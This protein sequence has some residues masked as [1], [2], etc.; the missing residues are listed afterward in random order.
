[1]TEKDS[2]KI[3]LDKYD[4]SMLEI[5]IDFNIDRIDSRYAKLRDAEKQSLETL[6]ELKTKIQMMK[7]DYE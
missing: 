4:L 1:M 3:K 6:K 2:S 5:V 7:L